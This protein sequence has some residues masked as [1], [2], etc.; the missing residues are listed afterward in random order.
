M[1]GRKLYVAVD[2]GASNGRVIVGNLAEFEVMN[3]FETANDTMLGEFHWNIMAI[4]SE[5]KK[6][7]KEAFTRYGERIISIGI[8][9]WGVD[10]GLL[11]SHDS[12]IGLPYHY[13]D[14]RTDGMSAEICASFPGGR[15]ALFSRTGLAF[16][17]FNTLYQLAA[18]KKYRPDVMKAAR[19]YLSIPDLLAFWLTGIKSNERSHASTTQLYDPRA[20]DWAWDVIDHVGLE[21]SLFCPLTD[22]GT[23][24]GPLT[25]ALRHELGASP[26]TVVIATACHDTASAVAAVPAE[27]GETYAYISSG[28]WSLLGIERAEPLINPH[29]MADGFTNEVAADGNIRLLKNI[30]GMWIQQECVRYWRSQGQDISWKELDEQ[31]EAAVAGYSGAIDPDDSR[32]LKPNTHDSLMVDRIASW[33]RE[34]DQPV[35]S[36]KGEY[37]VAI[38]RGLADVYA[39]SIT[40]LEKMAG[41]KFSSLYIIGGGSKNLILDNWT[42]ETTGITVHAGPVEATALGNIL[43]QMKAVGEISSWDEGRMLLRETQDMKTYGKL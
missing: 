40:S 30:M 5:V 16:Q 28:T 24:L 13:R 31:T 34:N 6:G 27:K 4:F 23:V 32:F 37:M 2:L 38:Y 36:G 33:C 22:S 39:K 10:Y 9:T 12:L 42:A 19:C 1:K 18:M 26:S 35:P 7:L 43:V 3:R 29:V 21:R 25:E 11:D 14:S 15:D 17:P 20:R 8:D 41:V